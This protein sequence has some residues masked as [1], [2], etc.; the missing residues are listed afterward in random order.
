MRL[1]FLLEGRYWP[2]AKWFGTAFARLPIAAELGPLLKRVV[3]AATFPDREDALVAA[4]GVLAGAHNASGLTETVDS[5]VRP[6]FGRPFRVL[7]TDRF[8]AACRATITDPWL[9]A[10]PSDGSVDQV[11]DSTPVLSAIGRAQQLRALYA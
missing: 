2:Y 5:S 11:V 6:F 8:A 4:Y 7:K 10:L 1:A 3:A 9:A